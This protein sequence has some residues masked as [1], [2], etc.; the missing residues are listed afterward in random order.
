MKPMREWL[1]ELVV[2]TVT[3]S[4]RITERWDLDYVSRI[5]SKRKN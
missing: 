1:Y 3:E 4:K 5:H 2:M